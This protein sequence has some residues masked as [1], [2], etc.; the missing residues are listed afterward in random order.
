MKKIILTIQ[1]I[2]DAT[3]TK[4]IKSKKLYSRKTKHKN[5]SNYE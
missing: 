2:W 1:E 5:K 4:I 3:K